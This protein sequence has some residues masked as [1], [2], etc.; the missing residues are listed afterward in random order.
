MGRGGRGG[1]EGLLKKKKKKREEEGRE[2]P[3]THRQTDR[4]II[5]G[6]GRERGEEGGCDGLEDVGAADTLAQ[7]E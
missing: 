2:A 5:T 1:S 6:P 7:E 3:R 4:Q